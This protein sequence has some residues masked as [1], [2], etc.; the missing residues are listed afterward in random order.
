MSKPLVIIDL[1]KDISTQFIGCQS[2]QEF[3][4]EI[5]E[6]VLEEAEIDLIVLHRYSKMM[7]YNYDS[8]PW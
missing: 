8:E 5:Q 7:Y 3:L 2:L 6:N 4:L 1:A